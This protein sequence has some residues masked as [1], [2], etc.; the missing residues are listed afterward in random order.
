MSRVLR[1]LGVLGLTLGLLGL[2]V[3]AGRGASTDPGRSGPGQGPRAKPGRRIIPAAQKTAKKKARTKKGMPKKD[4]AAETTTK[5]APANDTGLKFSSDI[6][7]ILVTNC[8]RCH[9]GKKKAFDMTSFEMLMKGAKGEKVIVPGMPEES[10]LV[11]RINGE[12][13][14]KMPQGGNNN[15]SEEAIARIGQWV[16]EGA[17]LDAGIDPKAPMEKYASTPEMLRK[18]ALA[19]LSP[20]ERDKAVEA[21]G[22]ERWKKGT[23]KTTPEVSRGAHFILFSNLPKERTSSTLKV[24]EQ[25]Y[26]QLKGLLGP[27]A[28]DWPEKAS[29]YVYNDKNS[30]V[31]FVRNV[32]NRDVDRDTLGSS[33][34]GVPQPYVAVVDPFGGMDEPA[35]PKRTSRS[36]KADDEGSTGAER[37]LSGLL[38]E[39]LASG[40]LSHAGKP[41]R[42]ITLG[43]GAYLASTTDPRSAYTHRLRKSAF[44]LA[45]LGWNAKAIEALGDQ[46]KP[47]DIRA[48]GFAI[49]EWLAASSKGAYPAFVQAMLGGGEKLDDVI[50]NVLGGSRDEFLG[51]SG[52]WVARYGARR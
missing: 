23:S 46:T 8:I 49:N 38:T 17:R 32:E 34:F 35:A 39:N 33:N 7:P 43:V 2:W 24:M 48:I 6:A 26:T 36:R 4:E 28:L 12:E 29:L 13:T 47:E 44:E 9:D 16:K 21:V 41:P 42:W 51:Y 40:V 27:S 1:N 18:A 52:Q 45:E 3:G 25:K 31:E 20:E 22:L 50:Q 30:F 19:K 11:L 15:L 14:P 5:A 37:S 10:H